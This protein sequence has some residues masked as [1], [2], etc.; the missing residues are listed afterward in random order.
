M[1]MDLAHFCITYFSLKLNC[2]FL[3]IKV[4]I[5]FF[6]DCKLLLDVYACSVFY[7]PLLFPLKFHALRTHTSV[8]LCGWVGVCAHVSDSWYFTIVLLNEARDTPKSLDTPSGQAT[9][10]MGQAADLNVEALFI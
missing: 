10:L 1:L 9:I 5:I 2:K 3:W 4:S 6:L 7:E 8:S